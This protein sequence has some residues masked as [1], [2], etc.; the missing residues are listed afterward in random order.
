MIKWRSKDGNL[1]FQVRV[2]P[3]ASRSEVV[4]EYGGA[5]RVRISAPPVNGAANAE[6]I[7]LLAREFNVRKTEV[8]IISG[9][10][11]KTKQVR[12]NGVGPGAL[13]KLSSSPED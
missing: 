8:D 9:L 3:R 13:E 2:V 11:G 12:I 1:E 4:G 10:A 5:L 7:R 6:L